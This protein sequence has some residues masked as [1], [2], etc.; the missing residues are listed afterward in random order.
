MIFA[1]DKRLA[2]TSF[3]YLFE[4]NLILKIK[5]NLTG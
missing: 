4:E 2:Q 1:T 3:L 5:N